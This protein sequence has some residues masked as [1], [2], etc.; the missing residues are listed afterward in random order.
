MNFVQVFSKKAAGMGEM[1]RISDF[2]LGWKLVV[3]F[4][5]F[6]TPQAC[7]GTGPKLFDTPSPSFKNFRNYRPK[8]KFNNLFNLSLKWGISNVRYYESGTFQLIEDIE[9]WGSFRWIFHVAW[10]ELLS[11]EKHLILFPFLCTV[12][13]ILFSGKFYCHQQS[14]S[15]NTLL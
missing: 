9:L 3:I 6:T 8:T 4:I 10:Q 2:N 7:Y 14:I 11:P 13:G 15:F 12:C 5:Q 1:K